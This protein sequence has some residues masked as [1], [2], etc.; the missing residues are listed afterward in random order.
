M[1]VVYYW[2]LSGQNHNERSAL[3][4]PSLYQAC[5]SILNGSSKAVALSLPGH[6]CEQ[7]IP[8]EGD[9]VDLS[10]YLVHSL[11]LLGWLT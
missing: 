9:G 6:I 1:P 8:K 10:S 7:S 3:T 11:P 2:G 5:Q 4:P